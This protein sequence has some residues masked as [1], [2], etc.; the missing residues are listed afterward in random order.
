MMKGRTLKST[1]FEVLRTLFAVA[2]CTLRAAS[3][4]K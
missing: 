2:L 4:G 1:A 3:R